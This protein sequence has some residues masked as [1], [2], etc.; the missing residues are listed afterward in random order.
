M[1]T[2][3]HVTCGQDGDHRH[4]N[5]GLK[6]CCLSLSRRAIDAIRC[7]FSSVWTHVVHDL[8]RRESAGVDR[9]PARRCML[10][11]EGPHA[12][13]D[14]SPPNPPINARFARSSIRLHARLSLGEKMTNTMH[15][16]RSS[17]DRP[18]RKK[19]RRS[20]RQPG[21]LRG[22]RSEGQCARGSNS[23]LRVQVHPVHK[24]FQCRLSRN[25]P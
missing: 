15:R 8:E 20:R 11:A 12:I 3:C 16:F 1:S 7:V 4:T 22:R 5:S 18:Q 10:P 23:N 9:H 13:G 14:L 25:R 19:S 24:P 21:S 6:H 17:G 2:H